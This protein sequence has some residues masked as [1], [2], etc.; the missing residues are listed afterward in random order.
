M[1][2]N[3]THP[4]L[5]F[6]FNLERLAFED[7]VLLGE[8]QSKC[9]HIAGVP[10][11][12]VVAQQLHTMFLVKGV[13]GTTA[14]EGNTLSEEE[15][16]ARYEKKLKLPESQEYLGR[17]V[18]NILEAC[19]TIGNQIWKGEAHP[20][21]PERIKW[22]NSIV[23]K[24]L[25]PADDAVVPGEFRKDQRV[26]G[27][28]R[29]VP[30]RDCH[31]LV[32]DLCRWIAEF[33]ELRCGKIAGAVIKAILTHAFFELI[34][35]FADGNGRTGRLIE[36]Q[37]LLEAGVPSTAAHLLSD[38]YNRTRTEYTRQL[39][40][41]SQSGGDYLPFVQYAI[42]GLVEGLR[43]QI[44]TIWVQILEVTWRNHVHE[45]FRGKKT[46]ASE[47]QRHLALDLGLVPDCEISALTH[48]TPRVAESYAKARKRSL[49]RDLSI[50]EEM[51][52][53]E[54]NNGKARACKEVVIQFLP[55]RIP[56]DFLKEQTSGAP[57]I[58]K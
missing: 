33:H 43:G 22:F 20:I 28:Y 42:R 48:L 13:R 49:L 34:H 46:E 56:S 10:L 27:G 7:W 52:L 32:G 26:V 9:E 50:L 1:K 47:R 5:R 14:I 35:P 16:L 19:N 40:R 25:D 37:L 58:E 41:I 55:A 51:K 45:A 31:G 17:E 6:F 39:S 3:K 21:T 44:R 2:Y 57:R 15:V 23:L 12:P 4:W 8:V 29:T 11:Q 54:T 24:D 30:W 53:V 36:F 38:H 18:D